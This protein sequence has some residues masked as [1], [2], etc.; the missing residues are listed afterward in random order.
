VVLDTFSL[1][2]GESV[3]HDRRIQVRIHRGQS[4]VGILRNQVSVTSWRNLS[5]SLTAKQYPVPKGE[6]EEGR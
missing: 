3:E 6:G 2:I 5:P 4:V 1:T